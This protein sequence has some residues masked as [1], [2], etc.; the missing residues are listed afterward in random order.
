[1]QVYEDTVYRPKLNWLGL[2]WVGI[3]VVKQHVGV[4]AATKGSVEK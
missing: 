2:W 3:G 4:L 1:M